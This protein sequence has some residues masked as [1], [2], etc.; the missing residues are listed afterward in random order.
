MVRDILDK[1]LVIYIYNLEDSGLD[2]LQI[3]SFYRL[4][5]ENYLIKMDQGY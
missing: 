1:V 3:K 5:R 4:T 2:L